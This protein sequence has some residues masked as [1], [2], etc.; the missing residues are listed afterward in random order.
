MSDSPSSLTNNGP[1]VLCI[2]DGWGLSHGLEHNAVACADTPNVDALL[3]AWPHARL[4][5]SGRDVGLPDGQV[6]NSEVGHMNIGAGRVVMQDLPRINA[7]MEDGSL[8][9]H[10]ELA[11]LGAT[12][13]GTGGRVHVMGLLS[14]G[15][16]HSHKDQMLAV[17]NGLH[18]TGAEII[19]HPF[20]DGRDVLP[21]M[22]QD[23]LPAFLASLPDDVTV[24][25]LA[26]R[27]FAMD[28]DNRW[29][30][31][32]SAYDTI[33]YGEGATAPDAMAALAASYDDGET[34]EFVTPKVIAGY[35]GMRDGDAVV[36]VNFRADR[37]RQI[38]SCWLYPEETGFAPQPA[39]LAAAIA[40]TSYSAQL[41]T[42]MTVLFGPQ[43]IS[44][45]LGMAVAEAGRR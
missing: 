42:K 30:R 23:E 31:T 13:A 25:T 6:G 4:S 19:L 28:R 10:P 8:A 1:V 29:E 32:K 33:A 20:T 36:M 38:L 22:A 43:Q 12:L 15:G 45:T 18:A 2:M 40:M 9:A 21:K 44:G 5:A 41:D 17:I 14:S 27:Y 35:D 16:V 11:A 7:A 24:G 37:V 3:A 26:G 34:D 39:A